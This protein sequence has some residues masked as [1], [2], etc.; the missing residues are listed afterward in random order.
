MSAAVRFVSAALAQG[1]VTKEQRRTVVSSRNWEA[2]AAFASLHLL[3]PA[4][5][6]AL[7]EKQLA[8]ELPADFAGFLEAIYELNAD[9][10]RELLRETARIAALLGERG[11]EPPVVLKGTA[12]LIT[13]VITHTGARYIADLD[14]LLRP[15]DA[16]EAVRIL[17]RSG[18]RCPN[19]EGAPPDEYPLD[20]SMY[21]YP[22]LCRPDCRFGVEVHRRLPERYPVLCG[23]DILRGSTTSSVDG[24]P[25]RV[26][27]P[28]HLALH[29]ILHTQTEVDPRNR[30][31]PPLRN[32]HDMV[33]IAARFLEQL[34]WDRISGQFRRAGQEQMLGMYLAIGSCFFAMPLP[35]SVRPAIG[36]RLRAR[37]AAAL[38]ALGRGRVADPLYVVEYFGRWLGLAASLAA[39]PAGR[40]K[41]RKNICDRQRYAGILRGL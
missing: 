13:G 9:R 40:S 16:E 26:P 28:E 37:H 1:A 36:D 38:Y 24:V 11:I 7:S 21:H 4:L 14:L 22:R 35:P 32:V 39:S 27:S 10:N 5:H 6:P 12:Y 2:I 18:M 17:L 15:K 34:D 31:L 33:L 30:I 20:G 29:H 41:L 8:G 19:P 25:V 23:D 3:A